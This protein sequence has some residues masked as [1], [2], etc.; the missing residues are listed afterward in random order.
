VNTVLLVGIRLAYSCLFTEE[1]DIII[2][3]Y[4]VPVVAVEDFNYRQFG[5][6]TSCIEF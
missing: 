6:G 2:W 1:M 4:T 3:S 5:R